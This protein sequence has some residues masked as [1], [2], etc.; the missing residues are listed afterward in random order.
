MQIMTMQMFV[1]WLGLDVKAV[2]RVIGVKACGGLVAC[3]R[4]F[5]CS[6]PNRRAKRKNAEEPSLCLKLRAPHLYRDLTSFGRLG[7]SPRMRV[8]RRRCGDNVAVMVELSFGD[9]CWGQAPSP[10]GTLW[11]MRLD[12]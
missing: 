11:R 8:S 7:E 5:Q 6:R 2:L 12:Y 4:P 9:R 1:R 3:L 10:S